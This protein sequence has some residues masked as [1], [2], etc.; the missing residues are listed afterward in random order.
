VGIRTAQQLLDR[1][2]EIMGD[3]GA[4]RWENP[5]ALNAINDGQRETVVAL[6]SSN[7]KTSLLTLA[8]G[9]RQ[10]LV[11]IGAA[12]AVQFTRYLNNYTGTTPGRAVVTRPM[13]WI[14]SER[15][16]WHTDTAAP[17][18]ICM[19]DP[20]EPL[21][22]YVWPPADGTTHR[23]RIS[24]SALPADLGSLATALVLPDVYFNAQLYYL[25]FRMSAK[26]ASFARNSLGTYFYDLFLN[27]LGIKDGKGRERD[28]NLQ[29]AANGSGVTG[30]P[31]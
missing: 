5:E 24:H 25:C 4:T 18:Q 7:V 3:V 27:A 19:H 12:D 23:G 1:A 16:T 22:F 8:A 28:P 29:M 10:D 21:V 20:S 30:G 26:Q 11:A 9:T 13:G 17:A 15:P 31:P 14:D 6:P 2:R